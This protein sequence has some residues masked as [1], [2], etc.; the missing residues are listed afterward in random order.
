MTQ[1]A[2]SSQLSDADRDRLLREQVITL[3]RGGN[4]HMPFAE[5]VVDFPEN[6][7]NVRPANVEYT[8]W[9]LVEHLRLTQA[10]ILDYMTNARY[11]APEWPREYWPAAHA[12]ATKAEWDAS[13]AAFQQDLEAIVAIVADASNDVFATVPSNDQHSLL[14]EVLIVA[15]H[16]A[17]HLG[18]LGILRQVTDTWGQEHER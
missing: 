6:L 2:S 9:H 16:N 15:D 17:Y 18:E 8:F 5:A 3:L 10:D 11:D 12:R 7:I 1:T 14:R 4:A 13:F